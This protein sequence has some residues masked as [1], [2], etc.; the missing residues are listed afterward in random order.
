[1]NFNIFRVYWNRWDIKSENELSQR[2]KAVAESCGI[3]KTREE[4][5]IRK[6][7]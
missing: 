3:P 1:M 6:T 7:K 4:H 5:P 2:R